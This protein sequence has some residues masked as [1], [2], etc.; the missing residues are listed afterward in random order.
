MYPQESLSSNPKKIAAL[1]SP[2]VNIFFL[3]CGRYELHRKGENRSEKHNVI[4]YTLLSSHK[5]SYISQNI[6]IYPP[7]SETISQYIWTYI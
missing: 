5:N 6:H 1:G 7:C 4:Q 2:D 3:V